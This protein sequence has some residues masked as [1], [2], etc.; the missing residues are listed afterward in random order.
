MDV[1]VEKENAI[2]TII[3]SEK[4]K[5]FA[6]RVTKNGPLALKGIKRAIDGGLELP[7]DES[8]RHELAEYTK[9]ALSG[10]AD[11]G[12]SAFMEKKTPTFKGT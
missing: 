11:E 5:A 6:E 7:L 8:L 9:V 2:A 12:I 1:I 10:D 4:V 3:N